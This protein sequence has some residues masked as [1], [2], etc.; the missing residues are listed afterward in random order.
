MELDGSQHYESETHLRDV[1]R[2]AFFSNLGLTVLRYSNTDIALRFGEVCEDI[3]NHLN[4]AS[5]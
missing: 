1:E 2:D 4:K 5:P 3:Y